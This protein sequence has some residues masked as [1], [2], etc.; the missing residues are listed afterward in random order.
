MPARR[1]WHIERAGAALATMECKKMTID[2]MKYFPADTD[3]AEAIAEML[4]RL[5]GAKMQ[6]HSSGGKSLIVPVIRSWMVTETE[7][8]IDF[9][10]GVIETLGRELS[11]RELLKAAGKSICH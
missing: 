3:E 9:S 1:A 10:P 8:R 7:V 2:T 4:K 6:L 11:A 5:D